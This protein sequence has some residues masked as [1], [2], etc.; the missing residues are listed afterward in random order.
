M[1]I[2]GISDMHGQLPSNLEKCD[3]LLIC[4]DIVPLRCQASSKESKKWF[5][6]T[7][8]PWC[9][10]LPCDKVVFIAGNHDM[11]LFH[12]GDDVVKLLEGQDKVV[13]LNESSCTF[14]GVTVYG[15]PWSKPF[16]NWWF[17]KPI[18]EMREMYTNNMDEIRKADI[19]ISH[20]APYECSDVLLQKTCPWANGDH[21]GNVAISEMV[22]EAKPRFLLHGH[23]HSTN[24]EAEDLGDTKVYNV[25]L[26]DEFYKMKY[27]P[28][29]FEI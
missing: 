12:H 25:S 4:G 22:I 21:I 15:T 6:N 10:G 16:G 28:L 17:M 18:E 27:E 24:H 8:F 2:C 14:N 29:Y 11:Y 7:F 1:R 3:M 23:L 9:N 5:V 26:I 13:Y 20:D 19:V